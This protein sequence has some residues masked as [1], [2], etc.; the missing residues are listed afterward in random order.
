MKLL[1]LTCERRH[2]HVAVFDEVFNEPVGS[3]Q[4]D[5]M[6]LQPLSEVRTVQEGITELQRR[7]PHRTAAAAAACRVQQAAGGDDWA[8]SKL[9][10][11]EGG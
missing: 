6:A 11:Q 8:R 2:Q 7:Q 10:A 1:V 9:T 3:L 5:L 4:L